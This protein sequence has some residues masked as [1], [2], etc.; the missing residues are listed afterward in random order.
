MKT[1]RTSNSESTGLRMIFGFMSSLPDTLEQ[2]L[3]LQSLRQLPRV[4]LL[5]SIHATPA[6]DGRQCL[7]LSQAVPVCW[8]LSCAAVPGMACPHGTMERPGGDLLQ[9]LYSYPASPQHSLQSR[10]SLP[11]FYSLCSLCLQN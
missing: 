1:I 2:G 11:H 9:L 10:R 7:W 5:G 8:W 4:V 3:G 6:M